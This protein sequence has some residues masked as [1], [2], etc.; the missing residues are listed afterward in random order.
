[1]EDMSLQEVPGTQSS[2]QEVSKRIN[3]IEK[4]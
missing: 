3:S 2:Q 4:Q 1:M